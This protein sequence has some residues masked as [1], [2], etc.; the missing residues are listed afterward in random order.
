MNDD[1]NYS[2]TLAGSCF[3]NTSSWN[4]PLAGMI[5]TEEQVSL[6][7]Q[8]HKCVQIFL[9]SSCSLSRDQLESILGTISSLNSQV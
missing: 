9:P 8:L 7:Q 2:S 4:N 3:K 1:E 6:V 5:I